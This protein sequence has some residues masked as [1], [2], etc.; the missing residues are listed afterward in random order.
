M[1]ALAHRKFFRTLED[2]EQSIAEKLSNCQYLFNNEVMEVNS[3]YNSILQL[4]IVIHMLAGTEKYY[5]NHKSVPVNHQ[6]WIDEREHSPQQ[7]TCELASDDL[8]QRH[9]CG[10]GEEYGN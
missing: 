4:S 10:D 6:S 3:K 1:K 7:Q 2:D 8:P 9:P 5:Y